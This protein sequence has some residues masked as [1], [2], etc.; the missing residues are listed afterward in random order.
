M[1]VEHSLVFNIDFSPANF[2][3]G[4]PLLV[5]LAQLGI[6]RALHVRCAGIV[7]DRVVI[8]V[9]GFSRKPGVQSRFPQILG[10]PTFEPLTTGVT[11]ELEGLA[12]GGRSKVFGEARH[13]VRHRLEI[14][15]IGVAVTTADLVMEKLKAHRG[16][17][18]VFFHDAFDELG[19]G[20]Y[21]VRLRQPPYYESDHD[22]DRDDLHAAYMVRANAVRV[23]SG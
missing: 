9:V 18:G 17:L 16:R 19:A 11:K 5:G 21:A 20:A 7:I 3:K 14:H 23:D 15:L 12:P 2:V 8:E 1:R 6:Q 13:C 4:G 10:I 22:D